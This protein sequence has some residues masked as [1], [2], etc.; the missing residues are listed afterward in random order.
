MRVHEMKQG[1]N[2]LL[3]TTRAAYERFY[4]D[5][6]LGPP[7]EVVA[8]GVTVQVRPVKIN[9]CRQQLV[10]QNLALSVIITQEGLIRKFTTIN[11]MCDLT[12][13]PSPRPTV[14]SSFR[15]VSP[16]EQDRSGQCLAYGE[17]FRLQA[18]DPVDEP[19]YLFSGPKRLNLSL[20]VNTARYTTKNGE[21]TLP[22]GVVS[23]KVLELVLKLINELIN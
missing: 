5:T 7:R 22:L 11:E 19:M 10:D 9:I 20:P 13:A 21:L 4:Q 1:G 6:V 18:M 12:V 17:K 8:F 14:R 2:T 3:D 16:D 15:I 23:H